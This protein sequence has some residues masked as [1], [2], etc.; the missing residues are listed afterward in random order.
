ML[1]IYIYACRGSLMQGNPDYHVV[2]EVMGRQQF[3]SFEAMLE[4]R[5]HLF[6]PSCRSEV[7][8]ANRYKGIRGYDRVSKVGVWAWDIALSRSAAPKTHK[9]QRIN[10]LIKIK[11]AMRKSERNH[12]FFYLKTWGNTQRNHLD[13][14]R[15]HGG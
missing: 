1:I 7:T 5:H 2:R 8:A 10:G 6:L 15:F 14:F 12:N 3:F 9:Q 4:G 13:Q 11:K